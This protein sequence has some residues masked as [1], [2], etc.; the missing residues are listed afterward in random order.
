M[1]PTLFPNYQ[2][3]WA[4]SIKLVSFDLQGMARVKAFLYYVVIFYINFST[5][6]RPSSF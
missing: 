3:F 2:H 1:K 5:N 4:V 6:E